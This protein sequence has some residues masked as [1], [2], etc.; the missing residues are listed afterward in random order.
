MIEGIFGNGVNC[1]KHSFFGLDAL[2]SCFCVQSR[3]ASGPTILL[4]VPRDGSREGGRIA[5]SGPVTPGRPGA[6]RPWR[7]SH[8]PRP[9]CR[10]NGQTRSPG[11]PSCSGHGVCRCPRPG[12]TSRTRTWGFRVKF[13][14][15]GCPLWGK[16]CRRCL[17]GPCRNSCWLTREAAQPWLKV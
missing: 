8:P 13:C 14:R 4:R 17:A 11:S 1:R 9:A 6:P 16:S 12:R 5:P 7:P 2:T 10:G 15:S 3:C